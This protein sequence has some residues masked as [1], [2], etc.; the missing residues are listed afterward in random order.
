MDF[1]GDSTNCSSTEVTRHIYI[2]HSYFGRNT[3]G[4]TLYIKYSVW[5]KLKNITVKNNS[6]IFSVFITHSSVFIVENANFTNMGQLEIN[7]VG[8]SSK[9]EFYGSNTFTY[10][11]CKE[12]AYSVLHLMQENATFYG[13]TTFL[14]YKGRY[15]G[16]IS[17]QD[18]EINFQGN[19]RFLYNEGE[20]GGALLLHQSNVSVLNGQC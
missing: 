3:I 13:N 15:G 20:Y 18:A 14:W 6:K 2:S 8:K 10:N 19:V 7:S 12:S 4:A 1:N 16:A 9:V 17:A 11:N 5:L